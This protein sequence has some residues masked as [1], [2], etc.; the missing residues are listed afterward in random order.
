VIL[1][2]PYKSPPNIELG[3]SSEVGR[4]LKSAEL[5]EGQVVWLRKEG[6][7]DYFT[8]N[9][10]QMLPGMAIFHMPRTNMTFGGFRQNGWIFDETKA[11]IHVYEYL[12]AD[13]C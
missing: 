6:R 13:Q 7:Q 4:E 8:A 5:K 3:N 12:G 1:K 11:Q 9:V 2:H 10:D